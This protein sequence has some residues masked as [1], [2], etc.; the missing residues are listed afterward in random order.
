M[1]LITNLNVYSHECHSGQYHKVHYLNSNFFAATSDDFQLKARLVNGSSNNVTNEDGYLQV[2]MNSVFTPS[3][4]KW[5]YVC[6]DKFKVNEARAF[7]R[8]LGLQ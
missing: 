7:C 8:K 5:Y 3:D 6:D 4:D 1:I 2:K